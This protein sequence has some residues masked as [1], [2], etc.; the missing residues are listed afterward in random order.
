MFAMILTTESLVFNLV[1]LL[2]LPFV[3]GLLGFAGSAAAC[4]LYNQIAGWMGGIAVDIEDDTAASW[5]ASSATDSE[6]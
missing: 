4:W 3:A 5:Y 2:A 1:M 6:S